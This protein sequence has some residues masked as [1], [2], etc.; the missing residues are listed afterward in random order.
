[1]RIGEDPDLSMT[2]WE[3]GYT[4]AFFDTIAVYHKRRVDF[5]KF[6]KQVYQFGCARPI[7]NQRHPNYVKISFA[8]PTYKICPDSSKKRY[9]PGSP[10]SPFKSLLKDSG[11]KLV[12]RWDIFCQIIDNYGDAGVCWRLARALW[13]GVSLVWDGAACSSAW[14]SAVAP[15]SAGCIRWQ[16]I[17][18]C[19]LVGPTTTSAVWR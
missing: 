17:Q 16:W 13:S 19:L 4:T 12:M 15:R 1:M 3:N 14:C 18:R 6:S 8:F 10:G 7:L 11:S 2:L 9:T 5:G